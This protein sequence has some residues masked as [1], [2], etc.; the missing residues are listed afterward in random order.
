[1]VP[2]T[3]DS[4]WTLKARRSM[5]NHS[6]AGFY[7]YDLGHVLF[8]LPEARFPPPNGASNAYLEGHGEDWRSLTRG[9]WGT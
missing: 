1:M 3:P 5:L 2:G 6:F 7:Q 4:A 9:R 8:S